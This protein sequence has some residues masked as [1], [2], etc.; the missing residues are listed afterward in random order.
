VDGKP[1]RAILVGHDRS[2]IAGGTYHSEIRAKDDGHE[3]IVRYYITD[4]ATYNGQAVQ[5]LVNSGSIPDVSIGFRYGKS[6]T[7]EHGQ[8]YV[9]FLDIDPTGTYATE[10]L[11]LS[12]VPLG[13]NYDAHTKSGDKGPTIETVNNVQM[14]NKTFQVKLGEKS[15]DLTVEAS[16][17]DITL[18]GA[19]QIEA[20]YKA[21]SDENASYKSQIEAERK[22]LEE[23]IPL[24][25]TEL[26]KSAKMPVAAL[27]AMNVTELRAYQ[28]SL[29]SEKKAKNGPRNQGGGGGGGNNDDDSNQYSWEN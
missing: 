2:A 20:A 8:G 9:T 11:E 6:E 25:E 19:D 1:G 15:Y 12:V 13:A 17:S 5:Y 10:G 16:E 21:V 29:L 23:A 26:A 24:L 28:D 18:K 4:K 7:K 22:P 27:K 14:K 3:L